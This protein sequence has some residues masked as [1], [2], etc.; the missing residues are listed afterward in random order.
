MGRHGD[1]HELDAALLFLASD[2]SSFV[3]GSTLVVDGGTSATL[4]AVDYDEELFAALAEAVG[5]M[6]TRITP[7][8]SRND[9]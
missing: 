2:A 5:E 8:S 7:S 1:V 9:G 6:A 4:G 3:T